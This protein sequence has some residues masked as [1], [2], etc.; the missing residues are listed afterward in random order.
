MLISAGTD[1]SQSPALPVLYWNVTYYNIYIVRAVVLATREQGERRQGLLSLK[2]EHNV[3]LNLTVDEQRI[4]TIPSVFMWNL[5]LLSLLCG[6]HTKTHIN[7]N[8]HFVCWLKR[9]LW[10]CLEE[11]FV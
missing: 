6:V 3:T 9:K 11:T 7:T 8:L 1:W 5:S 2:S 4:M 10:P